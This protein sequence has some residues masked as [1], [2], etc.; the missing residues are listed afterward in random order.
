M[1]NVLPAVR[2]VGDTGNVTVVESRAVGR[3][4]CFSGGKSTIGQSAITH[5][6]IIVNL[7]I[8]TGVM[9]ELGLDSGNDFQ[10]RL[11]KDRINDATSIPPNT[12]TVNMCWRRY[13][14]LLFFQNLKKEA[15]QL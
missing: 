14:N 6:K 8:C 10:F 1:G 5:L 4:Q 3:Y 15:D 13:L 11:D 7:K 2:V 12:L 9:P